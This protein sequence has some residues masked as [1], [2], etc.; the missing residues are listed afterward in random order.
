M[1]IDVTLCLPHGNR[2][3]T[4]L[5]DSGTDE[6]LISQRFAKENRLQAAPVGRMGIAVDGHQITIYGT[7]DL[8]IKAKDDHNIT[9]STKPAFYAT[10]M[11]HYDVI[12][13]LAWLDYVNPDI[14][15]PERKWFY[16]DSTASVEELSKED[17]EKSLEKETM[18]YAFYGGP[19]DSEQPEQQPSCDS[20]GIAIH[21]VGT[22]LTLPS[23]Y[24][25]YEDV[26]SKEGCETVQDIAGVTHAIDLEEGA[27]PP[28][29]PIYAL[30]E[31]ELRI[32]RD[33][34]AEKEAIGWIRHS[35]S[36]AGAPILFVPK[37][38]GS[39]R[40]CVDYRALNKVTVKNRH[41]LPLISETIDRMQGA[42][43]YTKLDLRDAYHRI[44]IK[45][46]DEWKTAFRTRYGHWE[47]TVMP[48]G[49]TNAPATF[50][51]YIN[52]TLEG[53]LDITCVAYLDDICIYSDS[54]EEHAKHVREVLD[55]LRKAGLYV[56]LS[57]CEFDKK[58][59]AFL[60]YVIGVHGIRMDDAKIRTILDWPTPKSFRDIQVFIGFANFYRRFVLRFSKVI[61]PLTDMLVGMVGGKKTGAF[62]WGE[63]ADK[64]FNMLK[65]LFTTAPIL[66]MFDPLLR[67]RLETDA[68]GFAIGAV[69]SQLFHDPIHGRDDWHPIA[70]WSRKMT[71]AERNYET[72]D[73]E[74]LAIV[75]AF[76]EW[77][78]YT[79]GSQHT[80]EVICDHENLKYFMS[81]KVLNRRQARWAQYLASFDFEILYRKGSLNPADGP[82]RR[83][84]YKEHA[85]ELD[86]T[87]LPTLQNKLRLRGETHVMSIFIGLVSTRLSTG[88]SQP[89][90]LPEN[91]EPAPTQVVHNGNEAGPRDDSDSEDELQNGSS[92]HQ[93][94]RTL[95]RA[96]AREVLRDQ[97]R[98]AEPSETVISLL[99]K[100]QQEDA[101]CI[102]KEWEKHVSN[103]IP[104]GD[105]KG[106]WAVDH[107]GLVRNG[108]KVYVPL[109]EATRSELMKINHDDPWQGGHAGR[110][111]TIETLTRYYW[112]PR[113]T[114]AVRRYVDT[115]DVCQ[116]MQTRRH[117]PYGKL[118]PLPRP[119]GV[120]QDIAMD[121]VTGLPPSLHRGIAYDSILVVVDRYSKMVQYIPCNKDMD[122]E[123]LA[124]I[125]EDR[126]FQH[127]GMFKS[128][129][130]D[131][132]S[133]FTSAWWAT[134]C[135][136]WGMRRK[137]STAFHPQ[138][139]GATERQNQT[140]EIF[141]RC[142]SN[143]NQDNWAR[144][145]AAGQFRVN[146]N[147]N[148]TTGKAPFDLVLRFRPE[149]RMNI[150]AAET[151]DSHNASG[152]APAARRE[153][154]LRERDANLVRDMWDMS[155]ATAKK[156]YDAHRKEISFA[157]GDE[158]LINAKNL[159]V[160][161]PCK[162]LTDRYVGPFKV[163]K[164]VGPNAY[165][166]ELPETYGRLHR[167]F[168][169]SLLEPYSRREGEEPPGPV[170]LDKEDRFQVESIRK[171]RGSKENPQFLVKWQG[172]PEHDNT[173]EP[174]DHLDDCE[175][176][177]EEFRMR[178][179]RVKHARH[180][181][182]EQKG[183]RKKRKRT[184]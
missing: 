181:L 66:R 91:M 152:E 103:T 125:M 8:R 108:G 168:P 127:Y 133:L 98:Y 46:G 147:I 4:A 128:C 5:L 12:L 148:R 23:K 184:K 155:Q 9:R 26:F 69:I 116:R 22:E 96:V 160:R 139:D 117:R 124:E 129:V 38:D 33:Y 44:R 11:T 27:R 86:Q 97:S 106:T 47:Y 45:P 126:V 39:L 110:D 15:W 122:A 59:I 121:F 131:R 14:H 20:H 102:G 80:V 94:A 67:T 83:P 24:R 21:S 34:L 56:K 151:E 61:C 174:L 25:E 99:L 43:I 88:S 164:S 123:E 1:L 145:L 177:I 149:M 132:G 7:H 173:W 158:V 42:K 104:K 118:A 179:E 119:K 143:Y 64:A 84:D 163:S 41:P 52:K 112:W 77:R 162:K 89:V 115:C 13:G 178:N 31:R 29:G 62:H 144:M 120:W 50:Q 49:L 113:V 114:Q 138:T 182:T 101:F 73:G 28:H 171:E 157:I 58:E 75:S 79:E 2:R 105:Y 135:H 159:R 95:P 170:D 100:L 35:K 36:P 176:L 82:S 72:H 51:A 90:S 153:V 76:K 93:I 172:Y 87:C 92:A 6:A 10:D 74:L 183:Q 165:E 169:V 166:L 68:S 150:E 48:F 30:S 107:A 175:D 85:E 40:L 19:T 54:I 130:S 17:F 37:P 78:Q 137:L 3:V 156:Y 142:Y 140:M 180:S 111:R 65:E 18:V 141:L 109:D 161:K 32:L 81:T 53:L 57:K 136:F 146:S 134:F 63:E 154:E 55:R 71:G 167:T 70:F 16:R 60:G